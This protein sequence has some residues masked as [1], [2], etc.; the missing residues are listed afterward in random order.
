MKNFLTVAICAVALC[1]CACSS[2]GGNSDPVM[3]IKGLEMPSP[4]TPIGQGEAVT[5]MGKG[6]TASSEI[7]L[8]A[9]VR[10]AGGEI[11]A[12]VD[13]VTSAYIRF[14]APASVTGKHSVVL[15]QNGGSYVLGTLEFAEALEPERIPTADELVGEW[16]LVDEEG[17]YDD[18]GSTDEWTEKQGEETY[19]FAGDGTGRY[20]WDFGGGD[21]GVYD[22]TWSLVADVIDI[23]Y[24]GPAGRSLRTRG[25][26]WQTIKVAMIGN[27]V[28][29]MTID[30]N[31]P[32]DN[33]IKHNRQTFERKD[34]S[35]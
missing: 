34:D 24:L 25:Y 2:E 12:T 11:M 1:L 27:D 23:T 20:V 15:K 10:D 9:V 35:N 28:L 26:E 16:V 13:E 29:V 17:Y 4:T 33:F 7:W 31:I 3:P 5:I 22:I 6:F 18:D 30:E 21:A 14:T 19:V 32:E 8:R